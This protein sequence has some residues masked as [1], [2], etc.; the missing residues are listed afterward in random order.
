[1]K[2]EYYLVTGNSDDDVVNLKSGTLCH[3]VIK[4][5]PLWII[6]ANDMHIKLSQELMIQSHKTIDSRGAK[7]HIGHEY[8]ITLQFVHN[9]I[10]HNIRVYY[11]VACR[12]GLIRDSENH[13]GYREVPN[14]DRISIFGSSKILLDHIS[15]SACEDGLIDAVQDNQQVLC[16]RI[17]MEELDMEI[18]R[19]L[20]LIHIRFKFGFGV[21]VITGRVE[22]DPDRVWFSSKIRSW[23]GTTIGLA[24]LVFG[25]CTNQPPSSISELMT[26][27]WFETSCALCLLF[28]SFCPF[29]SEGEKGNFRV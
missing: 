8:S 21:G 3:A 14:G 17:R 24:E 4:K 16:T 20:D 22:Y 13:F 5:K 10:I 27:P 28:L 7:V 15:I 29:V 11:I 2:G 18:R 12:D 23:T 25:S 6:F 19:R 1:M 26:N 9:V